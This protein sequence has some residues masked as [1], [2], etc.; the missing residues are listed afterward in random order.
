MASLAA[1]F[2]AAVVGGM[3]SGTLKSSADNMEVKVGDLTIS[4]PEHMLV[5]DVTSFLN[6]RLQ[7]S[8]SSTIIAVLQPGDS[9]EYVG[10]TGKWTEVN[11]D[12]QAG[13]VFTKY[14][15]SGT[16]L[17]KYIANHLKQFE[18]SGKQTGKSFQAVY[19]TKKAAR[20]DMAAY[21]ISGK[22]TKDAVIYA[23]KSSSDTIANQFEEVEK[24]FVNVD[25]LRFRGKPSTKS[26]I[27]STFSKGT[28]LDIVSDKDPEWMKVKYSGRTG[29]VSKDYLKKVNVKVSKSNK[30]GKIEKNEKL[31][32]SAVLQKW[33]K[34]KVGDGEGYVKRDN[35]KV[36]VNQ[37]EEDSTVVGFME[38]STKYKI[39]DV[40][41]DLVLVSLPDGSKGYTKAKD[42]KASV[43]YSKVKLDTA[44]I[45]A[46]TQKTDEVL[47]K[48]IK[49]VSKKR[50]EIV[51]YALQFKGN[52]YVWGGNSLT[53]GVDC[54]GFT[55]QVF[56]K[57]GVNLSRCSY[58]QVKNG[59]EIAF[60]DLKPGDLVFFYNKKL[61]RIGHVALYIGDNQIIHAQS[62]KTG[63][64]V[65]KW[66]YRTPYKAVNVL[67]E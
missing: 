32:V 18:V 45:A 40:Q 10:Q 41:K 22:T 43:S 58:Q 1:I 57:Y 65:S 64:V 59:K 25:G 7:P 48:D 14:A 9:V 46:A 31:V 50:K 21:S 33:V 24:A 62:K 17:K 29:Y 2:C 49:D 47:V 66:N 6:V 13:Y 61:G 23:T 4:V 19:K 16:N 37:P 5:A 8:S 53:N 26:T 35:V 15:A 51:K 20:D 34:I 44:A 27:Y 38:N 12:G 67:G 54:S 42:I 30:E 56:K 39:E 3:A 36:S 60:E 52:R 28:T 55:Q 11:I 63:I